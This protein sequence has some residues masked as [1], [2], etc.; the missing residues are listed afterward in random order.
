M[1]EDATYS[2]LFD[3]NGGSLEELVKVYLHLYQDDY[4]EEEFLKQQFWGGL[5]EPLT[6]IL[7]LKD[8]DQTFLDLFYFYLFFCRL[9]CQTSD[10]AKRRHTV[11][12]FC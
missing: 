7:L 3:Q 1:E 4:W 8:F 12:S 2:F 10:S 5:D 9:L 11:S 6:Q